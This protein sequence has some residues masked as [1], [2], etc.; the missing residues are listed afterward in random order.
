MNCS[1]SCCHETTASFAAA[2]VFLLPLPA[3]LS[4]PAPVVASPRLVSASE[5]VRSI[6]PLSPPPRIRQFSA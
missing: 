3:L 6:E 2:I 1:M 5:F 4:Q